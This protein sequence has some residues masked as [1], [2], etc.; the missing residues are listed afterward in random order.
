MKVIAFGFVLPY[1]SYLSDSWNK[2]DFI[3]L[4][5]TFAAT[6]TKHTPGDQKGLDIGQIYP[7]PWVEM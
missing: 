7:H 5:V 4:I 6:T 3:V 1:D 2:L